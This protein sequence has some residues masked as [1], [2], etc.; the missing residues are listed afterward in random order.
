MIGARHTWGRLVAHRGLLAGLLIVLTFAGVALAAPHLAPP[1]GEASPYL[2]PR[3]GFSLQ[4][5][6]PSAAHPL[7]TMEG[8]YDLFHGL[9]WGTRVAFRVGVLITLGRVLIGV[10]VGLVSGYYGGPVDGLLMRLT[11][12]F[13]AFPIVS[14]V[15]ITLGALGPRLNAMHTRETLWGDPTEQAIT[16]T[17]ILFGWM[18][19]ARLIRANVLSQKGR[20]Y[21]EAAVAAGAPA[22]RI[23]RR[24]LLPNVTQGLFVLAASDVGT[25]VALM[26]ALSFLGL[27]G[28]FKSRPA[29]D[30]G[31][32]L[33]ASRD[34]IIG[35]PQSAFAYWYTFVPASLAI[36]LFSVG[37]NLI[38]DGLRDLLDPRTR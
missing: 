20:T 29:A 1:V 23:M 38:G 26:S 3:Q 11:D 33:S 27:T 10:S 16:L 22:G 5:Q 18:Q 25:M 37:W 9:V 32:I 15:L 8:Q 31:H 6:P 21:V 7:G 12:G 19:Y 13:M 35:T 30:W 2:L 36:L 4:P 28:D 14:A 17:L 34:W 24:H